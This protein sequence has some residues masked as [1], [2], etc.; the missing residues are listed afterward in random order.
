MKEVGENELNILCE[1]HVLWQS[2][3][4]KEIHQPAFVGLKVTD[5]KFADRARERQLSRGQF[6]SSQSKNIN[7][8]HLAGAVIQDCIFESCYF[9]EI[10]FSYAQISRAE[11]RNCRFRNCRFV[12]AIFFQSQIENCSFETCHFTRSQLIECTL[13]PPQLANLWPI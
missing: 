2:T 6:D 13:N 8:S 1:R 3:K 7:C 12:K 4:E 9:E 10:D 11:F 5:S